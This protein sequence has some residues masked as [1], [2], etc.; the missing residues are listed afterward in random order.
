MTVLTYQKIDLI[1]PSIYCV[2]VDR[3]YQQMLELQHKEVVYLD[4]YNPHNS[5]HV[6]ITFDGLYKNT[7]AYVT[8]I[9]KFF[10]YPFELF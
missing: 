9:L 5:N 10:N 3:F 7:I 2:T 1:S 4:D 6:V 8:P